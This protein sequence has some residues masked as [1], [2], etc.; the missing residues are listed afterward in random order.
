LGNFVVMQSLIFLTGLLLFGNS[1]HIKLSPSDLP[2]ETLTNVA[3]GEDARQ[4]MDIYL[5]EGRDTVATKLMILVHGGGWIKGDK[6]EF[7]R[8]ITSLQERL[9]GYAFANVNYRLYDNGANKFPAQENDLQAAVNFLMSKRGEYGFSKNIVLV[10]ASAGAHLVLM[11]GYKNMG[12]YIP[13]A[14][15]SFF[16]PTDL[17]HLYKNPGYPAV[18]F[19][20]GGMLGGSPEQ[21]PEIY[22]SASPIQYVTSKSPPTLLLHGENDHLVPVEQSRLL[23][24]KLKKAGVKHDLFIYPDAGHGWRG[25]NLEDSFDRIRKFLEANVK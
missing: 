2:A 6:S 12:D 15:V 25:R 1:P 3:Y 20:L 7:N 13:R 10:G 5:P 21:I 16:G 9:N 23:K 17:E 19:L 24:N 4:T 22:K 11:Q 18:P 14:V 8:Y